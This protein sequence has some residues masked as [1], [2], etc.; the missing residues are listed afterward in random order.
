M[1]EIKINDRITAV[2]EYDEDCQG[3]EEFGMLGKIY[4]LNKSRYRLGT[5]P[6]SSEELGEIIL[7]I[8]QGELIGLSVYAYVH[9]GVALATTPF[10]C[11]FDSGLSGFIACSHEDVANWYGAEMPKEEVIEVLRNEVE[12]F[13]KFL[14]GDVYVIK[15]LVDGEEKDIVGGHYGFDYA[16]TCAREMGEEYVKLHEKVVK[17]VLKTGVGEKEVKLDDAS[18]TKLEESVD[19]A[20]KVGGFIVMSVGS[21]EPLPGWRWRVT[22][23]G[24]KL[25]GA[26]LAESDNIEIKKFREMLHGGDVEGFEKLED[27]TYVELD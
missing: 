6:V 2:L 18:I 9:S 25:V 26:I 1:H 23:R 27:G 22:H 19:F 15:I 24:A 5:V 4:Y 14:A 17:V 12:E 3:P 16:V 8:M 20:A 21:A 13:S 10:S 11:G 7:K